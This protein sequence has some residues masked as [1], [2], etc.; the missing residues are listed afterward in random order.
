MAVDLAIV[1]SIVAALALYASLRGDKPERLV[2]IFIVVGVLADRVGH[3]F[4][5]YGD[6]LRFSP[7][8][9]ALDCA[10][11]GAFL[12]VALKANRVWPLWIAASQLLAI[13]G[14]LGP[15]AY[16]AAHTQAYWA[17]TQMPIFVQLTAL[18]LGTA[19][20]SRRFRHFGAYNSWSPRIQRFDYI[21]EE[22]FQR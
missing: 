6:F 7:L 9:L 21:G 8:R 20:H 3:A 17:L 4:F 15:L 16:V 22:R 5:D 2:A 11:F 13:M 18:G 10:Q 19:A 14:G 12:F 1:L